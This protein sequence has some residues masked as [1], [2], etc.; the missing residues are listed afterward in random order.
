MAK[1]TFYDVLQVSPSADS[2]IIKAA[3]NSLIQRF[4]PDGSP[5]D[6]NDDFLKAL[7]KAYEVLSDPA[8][9]AGYDA[10][11]AD[12]DDG[13]SHQADAAHF[14]KKADAA[15]EAIHTK[16]PHPLMLLPR[17]Q[18]A[19]AWIYMK[20]PSARKTPPTTSRNSSNSTSKAL[21]S[22]PVGT[23]RLLSWVERGRFIGKCMAGSSL[24]LASSSFQTCSRKQVR[25]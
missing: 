24:F 12:A 19:T 7:N 6:P 3:Y 13:G 8:K 5:G 15:S 17:H 18:A 22:S 11:L 25:P 9:R 4:Y 16:S 21:G 1:N 20:R 14:T 2:E 10:A 23:G